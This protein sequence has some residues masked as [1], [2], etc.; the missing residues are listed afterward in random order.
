M[1]SIRILASAAVCSMLI[2]LPGVIP[3]AA[4][5]YDPKAHAGKVVIVDFWASWCKPCRRSFPWLNEMHARYADRG[6]VIVGVNLDNDRAAADAFLER[7][8]AN[9]EIVYDNDRTLARR[10]DVMAMPSS[11]LLGRDGALVETHLGFKVR[12]QDTYERAIVAALD[13]AAP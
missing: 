8:P 6:L 1:R 7:Y 9:F 2:A 12:E 13:D 3:V 10:F 11:Y 5:D 4:A